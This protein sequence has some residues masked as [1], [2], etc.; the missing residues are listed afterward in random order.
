MI[1]FGGPVEKSISVKLRR[2]W[3]MIYINKMTEVLRFF[4]MQREIALL[5][6]CRRG[7]VFAEPKLK[8]PQPNSLQVS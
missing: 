4:R 2:K 3:H 8:S 7:S 6:V 1:N 5:P